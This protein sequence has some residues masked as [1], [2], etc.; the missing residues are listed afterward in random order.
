MIRH[1]KI[2]IIASYLL[3]LAA[4]VLA[5]CVGRFSISVSEVLSSLAGN[6]DPSV[7]LVIYNLRLPRIL[8]AILIGAALAG[9]GV[10]YQ[11]MFQNPLVSPDIL[12]VSSGACIGAILS[13]FWG[14]TSTGTMLFAFATGI[15]SVMLAVLLS[16]LARK[17]RNIVLVFSGVIVGRFMSS[18]VGILIFFADDESQLGAIIEWEM[19]SLAK[20]SNQDVTLFGPLLVICLLVLFLMRWRINLLSVGD[21]ESK[22]LGVNVGKER[23]FIIIVATLSTAVSVCIAG[24]IAWIGLIVPHI[25]RWLVKDD[26]RYCMPLSFSLGALALIISDTIARTLLPYEMPLEVITGLVGAP[27]F[28]AIMIKRWRE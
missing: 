3:L 26:N 17:N 15:I 6:A 13:I 22:A 18:V 20:V 28:A 7:N 11:G 25:C 14:M 16:V 27:I 5:L 19:G 9:S 1:K 12:G 8:C 23:M 2:V 10:A 4:S 24:T 21:S